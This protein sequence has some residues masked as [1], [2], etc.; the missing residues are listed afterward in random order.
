VASS[1]AQAAPIPREAAVTMATVTS[2]IG[3]NYLSK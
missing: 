3:R 2:G 1:R